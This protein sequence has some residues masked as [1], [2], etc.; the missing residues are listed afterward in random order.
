[1][2][3]GG[4]GGGVWGWGGGWGGGEVTGLRGGDDAGEM[5]QGLCGG[6]YGVDAGGRCGVGVKC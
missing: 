6:L 5:M 4:V 1:V 2:G 3:G